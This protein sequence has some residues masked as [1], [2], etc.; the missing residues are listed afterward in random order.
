[1]NLH[2]SKTKLANGLRIITAPMHDTH[3]VAVLILVKVGSRYE[4]DEQ[5]GLSHFLEHMFFKGTKRRPSYLDVSKELDGLGAN[6][7]AFTSE[8]LTGFF[9]QTAADHFH[10][11]LDIL[12]DMLLEGTLPETE[13]AKERGVITEELNM[14]LDMPQSH[15]ADLAKKLQ[16]GKNPLG[17]PVIG[18]RSTIQA[19]TRPQLLDYKHNFYQPSAMVVAVA[20]AGDQGSWVKKIA[21]YFGSL[22]DNP[23][24]QYQHFAQYQKTA[25]VVLGSRKTDQAHFVITL[26]SLPRNDDRRYALKAATNLLG[27]MMSSRLFDEIREKRG[28]AYYVNA[29]VEEYEDTGALYVR[30]GVP[31]PKIEQAIEVVVKELKKLTNQKVGK[32]E[33]ARSKENIKGRTYLDLEDSLS[34]AQFLAEQELLLDKLEQPDELVAKVAAVKDSDILELCSQLIKRQHFNLAIVGPYKNREHFLKIINS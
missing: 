10:D 27:G 28:L 13:V 14:Y 18:T 8:E 4:T 11:A 12:A 30:A 33:L 15:V 9:V 22:K 20:G 32:D 31:V 5:A 34:V 21:S 7:N 3:A 17:R 23:R 2:F 1:M 6:F 16:F 25:Q 24:R 26:P 29:S 19:T